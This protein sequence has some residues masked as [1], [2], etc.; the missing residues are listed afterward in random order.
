MT[1]APEAAITAY[2]CRLAGR[3]V[4]PHEA[5]I[6]SQLLESIA[7]VQLIDFIER[8]FAVVVDDEDLVLANFDSVDAI[9]ALVRAKSGAT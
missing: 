3:Q 8:S 5:I 9:V 6:S 4:E 2:V 7:A 1:D